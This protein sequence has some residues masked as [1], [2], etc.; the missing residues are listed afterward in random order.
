MWIEKLIYCPVQV[1]GKDA[2]ASAGV[3]N[4][5]S[6]P[7]GGKDASVG[8]GAACDGVDSSET[9]KLHIHASGLYI[10]RVL[11]YMP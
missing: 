3:V 10:E 6:C 7:V 2:G 8:A 4:L 5:M 11:N 9:R 1:G